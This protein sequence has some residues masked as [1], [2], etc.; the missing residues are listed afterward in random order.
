[1][2]GI[3]RPGLRFHKHLLFLFYREEKNNVVRFDESLK[4]VRDR[5]LVFRKGFQHN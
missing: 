1:M 3:Q 4:V 2:N 5:I